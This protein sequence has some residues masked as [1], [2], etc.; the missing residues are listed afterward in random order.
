MMKHEGKQLRG[1]AI[2]QRSRM[3]HVMLGVFTVALALQSFACTG[4]VLDERTSTSASGSGGAGGMAGAGGMGGTGGSIEPVDGGSNGIEYSANNLFTHVPR[5]MIFKADHTRNICIRVWVEGFSGMGAF[6]IDVTTPWA[7]NNVEVT[8]DV[9]DC[10]LTNG[11]PPMPMSSANA[12]SG[13]GTIVVEG[14]FPCSV[15]VHA[16][17]SFDPLEPWI[18]ATEAFDVDGLPVDGGC[19]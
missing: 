1:L 19:G 16:T 11:F 10:A 7:V 9:N 17:L 3:S 6:N 2:T 12:L 13:L 4:D 8:N 18:P 14:A 5:F 15:S